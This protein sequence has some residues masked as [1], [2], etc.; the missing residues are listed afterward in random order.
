MKGFIRKLPTIFW[1]YWDMNTWLN[2]LGVSENWLM[3][4]TQ[5][6]LLEPLDLGMRF[7]GPIQVQGR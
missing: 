1:R 5:F 7:F 6:R 4:P 3:L 2:Y